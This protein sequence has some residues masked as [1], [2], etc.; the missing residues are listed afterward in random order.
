MIGMTDLRDK[1]K[2]DRGLIKMIQLV[3]PGYRGYRIKEDLR[4]ADRLLREELANRLTV[5]IW[6]RPIISPI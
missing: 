6:P 1:V 2:D 4:I 3:I 5:A